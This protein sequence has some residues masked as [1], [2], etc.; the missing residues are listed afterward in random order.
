M[1]LGQRISLYRK[2]LNISQEELGARLGVSRQAVSKWE[3]DLSTPD[4]NNLIGL[5]RELG[6]SVAELTETPEEPSAAQDPALPPSPSQ[7]ETDASRRNASGTRWWAG[8]IIGAVLLFLSAGYLLYRINQPPAGQVSD[9]AEPASDFYL[10]WQVPRTDGREWYEFLTLGNQDVPFP[11]HTSLHLTAPEKIVTEGTDLH[12]AAVHHAVCGGLYVDYIHLQADP[13]QGQA[14]GDTI[15]RISTM[16][17]GFWTPRG[18]S[19]GNEKSFV[20]DAYHSGKEDQAEGT[21]LYG[22]KEA[23]G[24]SLVPH[25]YLYIWSAFEEG[26]GYQTIYF[27]IKD[28]LV[29]GISMELMQD[30]G[31]FYASANNT[32]TF[33]VDENGDP[34]FSHRQDLPQEPIDATRQVY[35]AWN[36][37]VTNENLSAEERYAYRRDVFTNLPDMDWQEFGKLGG[38]DSSGTIFALLDWLSQQE[39]YSSGD[40]YFIQRGYAARG[41]DGA[42]TEDYCYLLSR[43]LFSDPVAYAKAL[44]RS[45]ADDEAVQT[46]I[47]GGTA[48]GADYYPADCETA[49]SALD[50]AINANAL[51]AEETGWAKLLRYYLANPNDG[52]YA[53]YPKTPAELEN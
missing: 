53:D 47:M 10:Q 34:D 19:V 42:Y 16:A 9:Y 50:A 26:R 12:L 6:V 41:I 46:L 33:P 5:A 32:S 1:T 4:L 36:Q 30:M 39:H 43:A 48:Y 8:L 45:T 27:F 24:Y 25:D 14:A 18:I 20:V 21:L 29:A 40:I 28:G 3:T 11:F 37:L 31:D 15:C 2:K 35:I 38:I 49:V 22:L 44:A 13:E 52:Y 51:T 23:D 17:P 7:L